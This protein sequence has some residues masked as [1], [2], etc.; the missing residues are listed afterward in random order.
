MNVLD[1]K[2]IQTFEQF[3]MYRATVL[4]GLKKANSDAPIVLQTMLICSNIEKMFNDIS[5]IN[6]K[7]RTMSKKAFKENLINEITKIHVD[8]ED[9]IDTINEAFLCSILKGDYK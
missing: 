3:C 8:I 7:L 6:V 4:R 9:A 1:S 2:S 5:K